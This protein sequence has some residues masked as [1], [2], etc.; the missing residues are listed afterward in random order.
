MICVFLSQLRS[1]HSSFIGLFSK[2]V[3]ETSIKIIVVVVVGFAK[4]CFDHLFSYV[5][6]VTNKISNLRYLQYKH[7]QLFRQFFFEF[8]LYFKLLLKPSYILIFHDFQQKIRHIKK[9]NLILY[10]K[11]QIIIYKRVN[12]IDIV[13]FKYL[14]ISDCTCFQKFRKILTKIKIKIL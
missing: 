11:K 8:L 9:R 2:Y 6:Q 13:I 7:K 4:Q 3:N 10:H 14:S 12:N 5:Q 1:F